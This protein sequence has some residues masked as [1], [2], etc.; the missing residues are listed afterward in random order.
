MNGFHVHATCVAVGGH[1]VLI[2]GKPG[3]GKSELALRLIDNPGYGT[4]EA[5]WTGVLVADDQTHLAP[6]DG[7]FVASPPTAIAGLLE[8]RGQGI[9]AL[10]HLSKVRLALVVDL[11]PGHDIARMPE[12]KDLVAEIKGVRLPRITLDQS[13]PAAPGIVRGILTARLKLLPRGPQ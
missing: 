2:R 10:P 1:G 6:V 8:L 7:G 12:E 4:G 3:S 11:M 13:Q 5:L 9:L